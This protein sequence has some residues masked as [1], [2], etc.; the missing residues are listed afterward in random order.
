MSVDFGGGV[1]GIN[2]RR[3][4]VGDV[5]GSAYSHGFLWKPNGTIVLIDPPDSG[6]TLA[7][8][9]NPRGDIVGIYWDNAA[10]RYRGFLR[11]K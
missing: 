4:I 8:G 3:D 2:S 10:R 9:V 7:Q 1:S 5:A 6:G 11:K